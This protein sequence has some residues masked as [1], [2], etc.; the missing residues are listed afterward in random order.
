MFAAML[1]IYCE[2]GISNFRRT[3]RK[4]MEYDGTTFL[5]LSFDKDTENTISL[6]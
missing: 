5:S 6:I 4:L 2:L 1:S 3:K